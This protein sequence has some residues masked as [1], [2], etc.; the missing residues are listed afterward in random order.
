[1]KKHWIWILVSFILLGSVSIGAQE[2]KTGIGLVFKES[3]WGMLSE[4]LGSENTFPPSVIH[5][6]IIRGG[7]KLEPEL[8]YLRTSSSVEEDRGKSSTNTS[9]LRIGCGVFL[10]KPVNKVSFYYGGRIG[11]VKM[12]SSE[13]EDYEGKD[14]IV[15]VDPSLGGHNE[16]LGPLFGENSESKTSQTNFYIG[17]AV[18]AEYWIGE[19]FSVGGEAQLL[20]T[21]YGEP[22]L[23]D[24]EEEDEVDIFQSLMMTKYMFVLRWYF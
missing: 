16:D 1:M 24:G 4:L 15:G 5:V 11:I 19:H 10:Y 20:Y 3:P 2:S 6:P 22:K 7:L 14:R 9:S 12:S 21:E 23:E 13:E 8:G 17:P 18:G